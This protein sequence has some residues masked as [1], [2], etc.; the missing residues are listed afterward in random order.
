MGSTSIEL[1]ESVWNPVRGCSM[2]SPGCKHCYAMRQAHRFSGE[3]HPY[4][5]LTEITGMGPRWTG[6][7]RFVQDML[8]APLHWKKPRRIFLNSM[9]D[10]FHGD[11]TNEQIASVFGVMAACQQHT[12]QVL[13]KR[14]KRMLEWYDWYEG[15]SGAGASTYAAAMQAASM[16]NSAAVRR[17]DAATEAP[18]PLP[19]VWLGV[20][21]ESQAAADERIPL[22]LQTPA[23]VRWVSAEPLLDD[24]NLQH[25]MINNAPSPPFFG[26]ALHEY[27]GFEHRIDW[28]VCGCES[29][30]GARPMNI[31][32][33]RSL[34]DQCVAAG[35]PFFLKQ[36]TIDG[37][38][39]KMPNLDGKVWAQMPEVKSC[40]K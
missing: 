6:R 20:S 31:D 14:P 37:E 32:W 30:P 27:R 18:W 21:V 17:L 12:F 38:L 26:N 36:A 11:I 5:G 28:V 4:E 7:A 2:V 22:L 39:V 34:R 1:T 13:T 24:I 40:M 15:H 29:G 3:G 8:A 19:N 16:L 25:V 9:S 10:L 35:V 33:A 23:A